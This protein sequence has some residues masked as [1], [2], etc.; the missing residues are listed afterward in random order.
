M[1][2]GEFW[3]ELVRLLPQLEKALDGDFPADDI[4]ALVD[5]HVDRLGDFGWEV[6]PFDSGYLFALSA[7]DDRDLSRQADELISVA[8][9][10]NRWHFF[11]GKP[12]MVGWVPR[13]FV[14]DS[15]G[16]KHLV[17]ATAARFRLCE[18]EA[19]RL[20]LKGIDFGS[21]PPSLQ[22]D[23]IEILL[24]GVIGEGK[25]RSLISI[26][27]VGSEAAGLFQPLSELERRG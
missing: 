17:D 21:A 14:F 7:G 20:Q 27:V 5:P 6:G 25:R 3:R 8:P 1:K 26:E 13:F 24:D 19:G 23:A 12:P 22:R 4:V 15:E 2:T 16:G 10:V 9:A 11:S 18:P